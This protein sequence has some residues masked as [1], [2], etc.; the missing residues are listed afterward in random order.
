MSEKKNKVMLKRPDDHSV[1][2]YKEWIQ[3][4]KFAM[5]GSREPDTSMTEA[6]WAKSC[7]KFWGE[8]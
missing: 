5:T 3:A 8:E 1:K 7:K 2:A 4:L 6:D